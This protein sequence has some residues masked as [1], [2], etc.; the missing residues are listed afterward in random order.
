MINFYSDWQL[1]AKCSLWLHTQRPYLSCDLSYGKKHQLQSTVNFLQCHHSLPTTPLLSLL[2]SFKCLAVSGR[3]LLNLYW[4]C[5]GKFSLDSVRNV[6]QSC[7]DSYSIQ[8]WNTTHPFPPL[9]CSADRWQPNC[10][11]IP[12]YLY[13]LSLQWYAQVIGNV[14]HWVYEQCPH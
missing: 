2:T 10:W 1:L 3:E 12:K 5:S 4:D 13:P 11:E 7:S 14:I 6:I 8:K 9:M